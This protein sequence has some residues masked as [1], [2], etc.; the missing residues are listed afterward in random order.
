[1]RQLPKMTVDEIDFKIVN[2]LKDNARM[3]YK[4]LGEQVALSTPAV[5]ERTKRLEEKGA[6]LEYRTEIDYSKFGYGIHAFILLKEDN[7]FRKAPE[8]LTQ[9]E[10]VKNCWIVSGEYD[11]MIEVHIENN[12]ELD[13]MIDELYLKIGRTSTKIGRASCRERV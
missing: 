10:C 12:K 2:A 4:K 6:I 7:V 11:Y 5:Y 1:M 13:A 9:L 3:S 8:F